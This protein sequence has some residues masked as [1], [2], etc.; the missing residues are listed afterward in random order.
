MPRRVIE[1]GYRQQLDKVSFQG[2]VIMQGLVASGYW[3]VYLT[4]LVEW[5]NEIYERKRSVQKY[6]CQTENLAFKL[7]FVGG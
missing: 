2:K 5:M 1:L 3:R 6:S 7:N 4:C